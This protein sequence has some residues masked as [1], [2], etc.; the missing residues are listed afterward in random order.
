M[1]S[2]S[3]RSSHLVQQQRLLRPSKTQ[4]LIHVM[5]HPTAS[6]QA[7]QDGN[8]FYRRQHCYSIPGKLPDLNDYIIAGC[9]YS[10]PLGILL[11][12]SVYGIDSLIIFRTLALMRDHS[13]LLALGRNMPRVSKAQI[14]VYS[15][16]GEGLLVFSVDDL[17]NTYPVPRF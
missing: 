8:V 10:G 16:A 6:W 17:S 1:A 13:K 3:G 5:E 7:M 11:A 4:K 9:K 12:F 14:Q 15:P 2:E